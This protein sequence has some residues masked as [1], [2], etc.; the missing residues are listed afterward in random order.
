MIVYVGWYVT[1]VS[2]DIVFV[3]FSLREEEEEEVEDHQ[4]GLQI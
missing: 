4:V 3:Y 2:Y 1:D